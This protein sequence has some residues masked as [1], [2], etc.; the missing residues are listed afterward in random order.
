ALFGAGEDGRIA[1]WSFTSDGKRSQGTLAD[2]K[3]PCP[4]R[5][6]RR[7]RGADAGRPGPDGLLAGRRRRLLLRGGVEEQEGLEALPQAPLPA[8]L[9]QG[10]R[11]ANSDASGL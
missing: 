11:G 7:V 6:G 2:I 3:V 4:P 9:R 1:F 5:R 8:R 10:L